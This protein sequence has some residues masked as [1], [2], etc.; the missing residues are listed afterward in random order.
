M[1]LCA[2]VAECCRLRRAK[3]LC[4]SWEKFHKLSSPRSVSNIQPHRDE[5]E[6]SRAWFINGCVEPF[7]WETFVLWRIGKFSGFFIVNQPWFH[8]GIGNWVE[9]RFVA[10]DANATKLLHQKPHESSKIP[11]S[12]L[13]NCFFPLRSNCSHRIF[14]GLRNEK[15]INW[16]LYL[17]KRA[18]WQKKP[19]DPWKYA[20]LL[21]PFVGLINIC[22]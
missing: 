22:A 20:L 5:I 14:L 15:K 11:T 2:A 18:S 19:G 3:H 6:A 1:N 9:N 10:V 12:T 8:F 13:D 4:T 17:I 21:L 7:W 16:N